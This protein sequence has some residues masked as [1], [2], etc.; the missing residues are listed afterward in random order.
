VRLDR[1]I[2]ADLAISD[3]KAFA[4]LVKIAKG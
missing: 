4:E 1:K 3:K 2:M